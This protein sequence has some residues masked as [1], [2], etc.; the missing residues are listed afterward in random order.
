MKLSLNCD[1][2]FSY[3]SLDNTKN[4][5]LNGRELEPRP[6]PPPMLADTSVNMW[7]EKAQLPCSPPHRKWIWGSHR[8]K[9]TQKKGSML[10]LKPR[11]DVTRS[12]K[13]GYQWPHEKDSRPPKIIKK[14][15][16]CLPSNEVILTSFSRQT[17]NLI[18]PL[19]RSQYEA[20]WNGFRLN[21]FTTSNK[22]IKSKEESNNI[23]NS[24]CLK[25]LM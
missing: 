14:T 22:T 24:T 23:F 7:I 9:N 19:K 2:L 15:F 25:W 6:K 4:S 18:Y 17:N 21:L 1:N 5:N 3:K 10:A 13:Q 16:D 12:P 20:Y 11:A 8:W